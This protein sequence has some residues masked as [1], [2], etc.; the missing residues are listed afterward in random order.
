[1]VKTMLSKAGISRDSALVVL[2]WLSF[3]GSFLINDP[4]LVVSL[5]TVA[6]VLP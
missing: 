5:Q 2:G 1:M 4:K 3:F 6:R